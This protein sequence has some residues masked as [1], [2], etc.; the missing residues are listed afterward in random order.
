MDAFDADVLI[1]AAGPD[2]ELGAPVRASSPPTLSV[3]RRYW[4]ASDRC[5]SIPKT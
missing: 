4:P 5:S 2:H 1:D 3:E